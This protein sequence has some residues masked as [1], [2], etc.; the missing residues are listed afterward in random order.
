MARKTRKKIEKKI[1]KKVDRRVNRNYILIG[2]VLLLVVIGC[3]FAYKY[4]IKPH[5]YIIKNQYYSFSIQTP[6]TWIAEEK[7]LYS[8]NNISQILTKCKN[9]KSKNNID[10]KIGEFRFKS[11]KYPQELEIFQFPAEGLPS[12][13]IF[14]ISV[15]CVTESSKKIGS[16]LV[17]FH[18]DFKYVITEHNYI[19]PKDK[20]AEKKIAKNYQILFNKIISSFKITK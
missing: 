13:I 9:D 20:G 1:E 10:Y 6:S 16:S 4:F 5:N 15:Y 2:G 8:E 19:S 14:E 17:F 12:G 18:D 11:Q 7:I 3:F